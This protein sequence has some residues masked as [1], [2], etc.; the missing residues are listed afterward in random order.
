MTPSLNATDRLS[1][2]FIVALM[3][4]CLLFLPSLPH[5]G[6]LLIRFGLLLIALFSV[7]WYADH[8]R[9]SKTAFSLH[10]LLPV[11][12]VP[13]L[14]DSL[15]DMIPWLRSGSF[16][17]LLIAIDHALFLGHHPTILLERFIH[18]FL[19][20]VL[21]FAYVSYYPMAT[22]LGIVLLSR[23]KLDAFNEAV[24]GIILCYYLSYI[25]YL[26]V[27]AVG[28]RYTLAHLQTADLQAGPLVIAIQE[29][30]N[31]LENTKTDAFPSGHTSIALMTLYYARVMQERVLT[32]V[33]IP[34]VTGLVV[35]T[36]YLRYH[37]VIDVLA[38]IG[39][40]GLTVWVAP[41]L[42]PRFSRPARQDRGQLHDS[43]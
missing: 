11:L 15:G 43:A 28:P 5:A 21:Q 8:H 31:R 35:S 1:L 39:L 17:D 22:V 2:L 37:Y 34:V 13:V 7:A 41:K 16:D 25:G 33:L 36:V 6:W 14:F 10:G 18:P 40:T 4:L 19:T 27:P 38:G 9:S 29:T 42:Y 30:L 24:F 3:T 23:G 12:I 20:T 32:A 26:L